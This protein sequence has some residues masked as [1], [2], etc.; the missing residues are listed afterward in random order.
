MPQ[1]TVKARSVD[2]AESVQ[3][4]DPI[5]EPYELSAGIRY[6]AD[7]ADFVHKEDPELQPEWEIR[8]G[9]ANLRLF[10]KLFG[11]MFAEVTE[12][13]TDPNVPVPEG[14]DLVIEPRLEE[15]EFSVPQQTNT[16]QYVVWLRYNFRFLHP[17][18]QLISDWRVT[19]YGQE[20]ENDLGLGSEDAMKEAAVKA[21]RDVAASVV[22]GFPEAPGVADQILPPEPTGVDGMNFG[23][24]K[25]EGSAPD[26]LVPEKD[27]DD[28]NNIES[29]TDGG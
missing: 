8:L 17:D 1:I 10:R 22:T 16:D 18:G 21:L 11:A 26:N 9:E 28:N 12:L 13:D 3:F 2:V 19:A 14:I 4:P 24:D 27:S 20:D 15:L 29:A 6:P 23:F 5:L 25:T 7:V